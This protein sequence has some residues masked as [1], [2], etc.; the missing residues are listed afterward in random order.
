MSIC[1]AAA[2][3]SR[4]P[5][6]SREFSGFLDDYSLL[7]P[8]GPGDATLVYRDPGAPWTSYDK[9]LFEAVT[10]WRSG[11]H[12]LDAVPE[13]DLQR[14]AAGLERAVR[15]RLGEGFVV[16]DE[17]ADGT[18]RIRLAITAARASDP[19]LDVLRATSG[20]TSAPD[21]D[22]LSAE[23]RTF[24]ASAQIEGDIRDAQTDRLLAAGVDRRRPDAPRF[25][26]WADVEHAFDRWAARTCARLETRAGAV[27]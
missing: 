15:R 19:V 1:L 8:G 27:H 11:R 14:L 18:M 13:A 26:T 25:E 4:T 3:V 20:G 24:I 9:V 7:R 16:V 10:V 22:V 6:P 23:T 17:P 5:S 2:C 21:G 12:S